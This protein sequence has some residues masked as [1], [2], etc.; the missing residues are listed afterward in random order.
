[1]SGWLRQILLNAQARSGF[2]V[3]ILAWAVIGAVAAAAAI[4]FLA[5]AAFI[6]LAER[7]DPVIAG[8]TLAFFCLLIASIAMVACMLVRRRN[9]ERA[10]L[11]LAARS[12]TELIDPR[13]LA[14]GL[15]LGQAVGW[16]K[17]ATLAAVGLVAALVAR[18]W[19]G[20]R[21][22]RANDDEPS[23]S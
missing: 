5:I 4:V 2:S 7:Y 9:I 21:G 20:G 12:N 22:A 18:E 17:V 6:W 14:V 8:L 1:M 3:H 23:E 16:R 10:R 15:Q 11:E 13:F 19:L